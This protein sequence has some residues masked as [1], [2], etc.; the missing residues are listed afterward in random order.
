ME[1]HSFMQRVKIYRLNEEGN[2]DDKG[3]GHVSVEYLE[4]SDALGLVVT[5]EEDNSTLLVHQIVAD[6]LYKRQADT[7]VSWTDNEA[8]TDLALSF[9]ETAGCSYIWDQ[10]CTVQREIQFP[11]AHELISSRRHDVDELDRVAA[12]SNDDNDDRFQ[13]AT[14]S[15]VD[16]PYAE[17]NTEVLEK[18]AKVLGEVTPFGR[19][20]VANLVLREN[21]LQRLFEVFSMC[22]DLENLE[23]LRCMY[24]IAKGLAMLN[25][26]HVFDVILHEDHILDL[27]G[28]LEYDPE[29]PERQEH[30]QFLQG[31]VLYKEVVP[32]ADMTVKSKI[33]QTYR[34]GYIKDVILPRV[35][36]DGTFA[37]LNSLMLFNNVEVVTALQSDPKFLVELFAHLN[38]KDECKHSSKDWKDLVLF[39]QELCSLTKHLQP[40]QRSQLFQRM[41]QH[42][43]F[44]ILTTALDFLDEA[45]QLG[46]ADVMASTLNH[47]PALLR[48]FMVSQKE[49][50]LF[51]LLVRGFIEGANGGLQ[52]QLLEILRMLLDPS[53]MEA[54]VEKG[55]FLEL[56]Y[57]E[58][59]K[60]LISALETGK[61][62]F[63]QHNAEVSNGT[64]ENG[65]DLSAPLAPM[66]LNYILEL[67]CFCVQHHG[68]RI[69]YYVLRHNVIEKVLRPLV[70]RTERFLVVAAIRLFRTCIGLKDE[71]Y[72]RYLMKNNLFEIIVQVFLENGAKYNLLNSAIIELFEFIR[73]NNLKNVVVHVWEQ[74]GSRLEDITY[75][76]TF[77][78]LKTKY[79]QIQ[80]GN[81]EAAD[82]GQGGEADAGPSISRPVS[83]GAETRLAGRNVRRRREGSMDEEEESYFNEDSDDDDSG[84]AASVP[85]PPRPPFLANGAH[86]PA[87]AHRGPFGLVDYDDDD[88]DEQSSGLSPRSSPRARS[89]PLPPRPQSA[90]GL[91]GKERPWPTS[92]SRVIAFAHAKDAIHIDASRRRNEPA[93]TSSAVDADGERPKPSQPASPTTTAAEHTVSPES[94]VNVDTVED[95]GVREG[96]P[97]TK[98][99][100]RDS[101]EQNSGS[102]TPPVLVNT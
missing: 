69:K 26:A 75:V 58:Y 34:I 96:E 2:W 35:L 11:S 66:T 100:R 74:F 71:F 10:L 13:Q 78:Q 16:L 33:H 88:D 41:N 80:D 73:K 83:R 95:A 89:P 102:E 65:T 85:S 56:F 5:D 52:A 63:Q 37:T 42:G 82:A 46:A 70:R 12:A 48:N 14:V 36:D 67:L 38:A 22:E 97:F 92:K 30:R 45:V 61:S 49:H 77:Q 86:A 17:F 15:E 29:A 3:T 47:D 32:I 40:N 53:S 98:R 84:N 60:H 7:I 62:P 51:T 25:E 27:I 6:D 90:L 54:L 55:T 8:G 99:R 64:S 21:W 50:M 87:P 72:I 1:Y 44:E 28:C 9:Q 81:A 43:L 24:R 23:A 19:E 39:L 20:Q 101:H 68:F 59:V 91:H 93:A 79:E 76:D 31:H 57:E 4:H 18:I 94:P